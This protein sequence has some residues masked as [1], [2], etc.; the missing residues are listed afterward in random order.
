MLTTVDAVIIAI[1]TKLTKL[2]TE[3]HFELIIRGS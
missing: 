3:K 1:K 2:D